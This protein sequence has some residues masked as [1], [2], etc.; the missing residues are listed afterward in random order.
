M[1][2]AANAGYGPA[3]PLGGAA[4]PLPMTMYPPASSGVWNPQSRMLN[5]PNMYTQSTR[6]P[7]PQQ[8]TYNNMMM[9]PMTSANMMTAA[10]LNPQMLAMMNAQQC[11]PMNNAL[12]NLDLPASN[13][14]KALNFT[15]LNDGAAGPEH[16]LN[17]NGYS[18][19]AYGSIPDQ[20]HLGKDALS[21]VIVC[22]NVAGDLV[23]FPN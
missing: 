14:N 5:E 11:P 7:M 16:D 21:V 17:H 9:P 23:W 20:R 6:Y 4:K 10:A 8:E 18:G 12:M 22:R 13:F 2:P 19:G 3:D 15:K 1:N